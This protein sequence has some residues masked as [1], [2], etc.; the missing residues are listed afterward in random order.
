MSESI[1]VY[2]ADV[3]GNPQNCLYP[4]KATVTTPEELKRWMAQ[5]HVFIRF[6]G[7]YRSN[8][9][10]EEAVT[11]V[12][13]CDNDFTENAEKWIR[14]EDIS[15]LFPG[16]SCAVSTSRNHMKQ[17]G[18]K[19][20]RPR[21]HIIFAIEPITDPTEYTAFMK[22]VWQQKQKVL[23]PFLLRCV[24]TSRISKKP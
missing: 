14:P 8:K 1:T 13:D 19:S 17:K 21:F 7:N 18:N 4:H 2:Y 24:K 16:V 20:P 11:A 3:C 23:Q 10:F 5:D 15:R 6:N 22:T 9:N 12:F